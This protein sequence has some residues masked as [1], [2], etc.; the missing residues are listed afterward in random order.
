MS[1]KLQVPPEMSQSPNQVIAWILQQQ[2][3]QLHDQRTLIEEQ[4]KRIKALEDE[5]AR[6][7][8][9]TV[10]VLAEQ[11]PP[12]PSK[13]QVAPWAISSAFGTPAAP[14]FGAAKAHY[15]Q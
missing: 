12:P 4:R 6:A 10:K 15:D 1:A 13:P 3:D 8:D 7:H 14:A 11:R 9:F 5:L 2:Q